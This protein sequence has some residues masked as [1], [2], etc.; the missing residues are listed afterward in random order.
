LA[1]GQSFQGKPC[2]LAVC[3]SLMSFPQSIHMLTGWRTSAPRI[4]KMTSV[5]MF[6][7]WSAIRSRLFA[8]RILF[9]DR[10]VDCG[11]AENL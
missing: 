9:V 4:Q 6:E 2:L 1:I 5:A 7:A 11:P 3:L 8:T 10:Y